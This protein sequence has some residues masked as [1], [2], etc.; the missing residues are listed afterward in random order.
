[1]DIEEQ[2]SKYPTDEFAPKARKPYTITKQR[3]RWSEEEHSR[4]LEALKLHGRAW[5]KIEEHIG[6]K[7]AVQIR[8]H[9]QKFFCKV[10]RDDDTVEIPPPRPKRKPIHPYPR[11]LVSPVKGGETLVP[12]KQMSQS[13][14]SILS[15][16]GSSDSFDDDQ[17]PSSASSPAA[18]SDDHESVQALHSDEDEFSSHEER[19]NPLELAARRAKEFNGRCLKLFGQTLCIVETDDDHLLLP[20]RVIPL[21]LTPLSKTSPWLSLSINAPDA[22]N[23]DHSIKL[24]KC[25]STTNSSNFGKKGFMPYRRSIA[26]TEQS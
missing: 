15:A 18:I 17:S 1:M 7:T 21:K 6:T 5:R 19:H 26:T 22:V 9:A 24:S 16:V 23:Y 10:I 4:F 12:E 13:P 20:L 3:E 2:Q 11:K 14:K 8:S 25:R